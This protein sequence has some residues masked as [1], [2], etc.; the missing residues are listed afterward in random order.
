[1]PKASEPNNECPFMREM[2][3]LC[4]CKP[5]RAQETS[6]PLKRLKF[7]TSPDHRAKATVQMRFWPEW[8]QKAGRAGS[9][10][11]TSDVVPYR[12]VE[13]EG[14]GAG[15]EA[16]VC[17][18]RREESFDGQRCPLQEKTTDNG[19]RT[20]DHRP[21]TTRSRLIPTP[22][23]FKLSVIWGKQRCRAG[24][25]A[26]RFAALFSA[27]AFVGQRFRGLK[28]PLNRQA[29]KPALHSVAA[30]W[31][32]AGWLAGCFASIAAQGAPLEQSAQDQI[33]AL[34]KEK[35]SWTP[36]QVKMESALIHASKK[37]SGRTFAPGAP[38]LE[39]DL[40]KESDGRVLVDITAK[41]T[42]GLLA[43]I[44]RDGGEVV[45]S[46]PR[47]RAI[48]AK[49]QIDQLEKLASHGDVT[50]IKRAVQA[51]A[52]TGSVNSQGDATHLAGAA[53]SA[54]GVG[55]AG[56]KV[57]VLSDSV[58]YL[59]HSQSLG[60]LG[61][62]TVL[63]GQAGGGSGEGTAML[64][65]VHDLAPQAQLYFATAFNG[66][67]SFAQNI[68][69][70]R[71]NGCNIIIDDVGYFD[72]SPFQDGIIAQ[73][74][75]SVTAGGA[76][77]FSSAGN[78][79]NLTAGTSGTW[80][81]DF[82][83]GGAA[84]SAFLEP[85]RVHSFGANNY[86]VVTS[87]GFAVDLFWADPLGA[88]TNDY[89]LFLLDPSGSNVVS[90]SM[91]RQTGTQDPYEKLG[92]WETGQR[93]VIVKYSGNARFLHLDTQR[94]RLGTPTSGAT[95]G[96]AATTNAFDVAATPASNPYG[97][98]QAGPFP[99]PFGTNNQVEIFSS[100]GPRHVFFQA[101][102]TAITPG[103][104]TNSGGAVRQKPD[105]TAADGVATTLP[106]G[107]GLNPFYGTSAAAPHAGGLAALIWSYNP[108][109][110]TSQMRALLTTNAVDIGASGVDRDS[111][112][113][114]VMAYPALTNLAGRTPLAIN[115]QPVS[116]RVLPGNTASFNLS[117]FGSASISYAW[118]RDGAP[119]AGA[120]GSSYSLA[121][122]QIADSGAQFS[123]LVSNVQGTLL[124]SN[125]TLTIFSNSTC[126][127][128]TIIAGSSYSTAEST[129]DAPYN[130]PAPSCVY[131]FGKGVWFQ[132]TA[133]SNG[134]LVLDT[135]GSD[136]N[137]GLGL[138]TGGCGALNEAGCNAFAGVSDS[139]GFVF[140]RLTNSVAAGT[141]YYI[142][143]G[144]WGGSSGGYA[145]SGNLVFQLSFFPFVGPPSIVSQ[146]QDTMRTAGQKAMFSVDALG[147][148]PLHYQWQRGS[149]AIS[150]ATT[151]SYTVLSSQAAD[152]GLYN[153]VI[154]NL[155]GSVT[156]APARLIFDTVLYSFNG[157][158]GSSPLAGLIQ[159]ND[160]NFYG[161]TFSGGPAGLGTIFKMTTNGAVSTLFNFQAY[162]NGLYPM[163]NLVQASD[164]N[165]YGTTYEGG[166]NGFG[167]I[168][169]ISVNGVFSVLASLDFSTGAN[170][171]GN[172]VQGLD[173]G[174]YGEAI[175]GGASDQG[176]IFKVTTNGLLT[177]VASFHGTNGIYPRGGLVQGA[178]GS[179]Y[180]TT[181]SG[182]ANDFG[183]IFKISTNGTMTSLVSFN[184]GN[185]SRPRGLL[186]AA[187]GNFYGTTESGFT[188]ST[189]F[190]MTPGGVITSFFPFGGDD[191]FVP[192]RYLFGISPTGFWPLAGLVQG[193]DGILYGTALAGG[194]LYD[195]AIF[196]ITTNGVL[197]SR[198]SLA[199]YNGVW[200]QTA[201]TLGRDG[202]I[203]GTTP[204][205]GTD[206]NGY[207][208][209]YASG[210]G[211][212]FRLA[213]GPPSSASPPAI[214]SE[215][216]NRIAP[217]GGPANFIVRAVSSA[218]VNYT[219]MRNGVPMAGATQS[220]L[221]V[222]NIQP[223]DSGARFSCLVSNALGSLLSS[224]AILNVTASS[225]PGPFYEF[226]GMDGSWPT[227][228][229]FQASDGNFYGTTPYG[230]D[231]GHG[232]LFSL[233]TNGVRTTLFS[234]AGTNGSAPYGALTQGPD[235]ALYGTTF[236][237]GIGLYGADTASYF[238]DNMLFADT[239]VGTIFRFTTKGPAALASF[240]TLVSL[241]F[242][243]NAPYAGLTL[244]PDGN[245]YGTSVSG[246]A[247]YS[248]GSIFRMTPDG[249]LTTLASFSS[250]GSSGYSPYGGLVYGG[251]GYFYGTTY[252]GG[253][254]AYGTV[255]RISTNGVLTTLVS[256]NQS[257]GSHPYSTLA[258]GTDGNFYGTTYD[259]GSNYVGTVF[260]VT[261]GGTLTSLYSFDGVNGFYPFG[262]LA[263]G[264]DGA[265]YGT[266]YEGGAAG[267]GTVYR[268]TSSG[269][270]T[271]LFSLSGTNGDGGY[272]GLMVARD[273]NLYSTANFGGQGY[274]LYDVKVGNGT[275]VRVPLIY[276]S[277]P[278]VIVS[279]PLNQTLLAG[280]TA[281]FSISAGGS[282]PLSYFWRRNGSTISGATQSSYS[283][284][285]MQLADSG[286]QFSCLVSN[287]LG[288]LLSSNAVLTVVL[289]P[290]NTNC[291]GATLIAS[292]PYST[293]ES[294]LGAPSGNPTPSC[295]SSFGSGVWFQY[296]APVSQTISIDSAGSD[297][298]TALAVYNGTCGT[299]TELACNDDAGD[300]SLNSGVTVPVNTGTTYFI[301]AGGYN[302]QT[303]NLA[304]HV[305]FAN[306]DLCANATVITSPFFTTNE[307]TIG[308][309]SIGDPQPPCVY[310]PGKGVWFQYTP[311]LNG[312]LI[313][314]T[315]GSSF[316]TV[317][318]L[319]TGSCGA[320]SPV[321]CSGSGS[322]ISLQVT[323]GVTYSILAAG[324]N[325]E[326][327]NLVFHLN[328]YLGGP[329]VVYGPNSQ[330][331]PVGGTASFSVTAYGALPLTYQW[332]HNGTPIAGATQSFYTTNNVP[333]A[334][335]GGQFSC[336]VSNSVGP[337]LSSNAVLTVVP[338]TAPG[339]TETALA[340][341]DFTNNVFNPVGLFQASDGYLYGTADN[342]G[343]F[344]YG[345][346][347]RMTT[348]GTP[349]ILVSFDYSTNG[350]YP[351][352][353]LMQA[354]DGYLYGTTYYGGAHD[355][356][357]VFRLSTNGTLSTLFSFNYNNGAQPGAGVIQGFDGYFYGTTSYGGTNGYGTVF[358]MT[359]NGVLTTLFSFGDDAHG[360]SPNCDL[361][362]GSDGYLYG[363]TPLGGT[364]ENGTVFKISTNGALTTLALFDYD[365]GANPYAGLTKGADGDFYGMAG[366]GG[367]NGYGTV[368][369][370]T[371]H[372]KL[373]TL[374][375]FA[376]D[377]DGANPFSELIQGN[378]GNFYGTTPSG[379]RYGQ[380]VLFRIAPNGA[381][382][383]M[384]QFDGYNGSGPW[385]RL[386]QAA[387]AN[388]YGVANYGGPL[389]N[390][391]VFKVGISAPLQIISQPAN[392]TAFA[393]EDVALDVAA[394]G[395]LP[396]NFHWR[397]RGTNLVDSGNMAGAHT[398][399][400]KFT[401]VTPANAGLYQVVVSNNSMSVTSAA[402]FLQVIVSP[403]IIVTQPA[404]QSVLDGLTA[405]FLVEAEG[406]FPLYYQWLHDGTNLTD[407]A[408]I[409]GSQD[410][411]LVIAA[412]HAADGGV[413]S[414]LV[415][416]DLGDVLSD[417]AVLA[418]IPVNIA[419]TAF[420]EL[421]TFDPNTEGNFVQSP[422]V[423][424]P[425]GN[426]Y[427][428]TFYGGH[429]SGTVFRLTKAGAL[430]TMV[431]FD[432]TNGANPEAGLIVGA[433]G[434]LYGVTQSTPGGY[435][436]VFRMTANGSLATVFTF[437]SYGKGA[438]ARELMQA[439]D[440]NFYGVTYAGGANG[441]GTAFRLTPGGV[442]TTLVNFDY[443]TSGSYPQA[444]LVQGPGGI[445][446]GTT[447]EG[448]T[449]GSGAVFSLT[450][451]GL[452][453][454]RATFYGT[455]GATPVGRLLAASDGYLYGS[456]FYGGAYGYG[457]LF[458]MA[459]NGALSTLISFDSTSNGTQAGGLVQGA[460]SNF[461]GTTYS[462]GLGGGG[463]VFKLTPGGTL[464]SIVWFEGINGWGPGTRMVQASD[465][466][467]YGT[468]A[469]IGG[470]GVG[471]DTVFSLTV[472][473]FIRNPFTEAAASD[474]SAYASSLLAD[475]VA[476][477]GDTL[478]FAKVSGPAW[479]NVAGDG[480]L[481][482][483]PLTAN[484]GTNSF[485]VGLSDTNG[486]A[487]TATM[488]IVVNPSAPSIVAQPAGQT[489]SIGA[490]AT[491]SVSAAGTTP[492]VYGWRRNGAPISGT[493]NSS[494]TF[495]NAQ[496]SDSG[497]LFSCLVTNA[498]GFALSSNA[499]L[500]VTTTLAN[501]QCAGAIVIA[502]SSYAN[503]QSTTYASS[504]SDPAPS[505]VPGFGNGVWYQ[506]ATP[507]AGLLT[508]DT[509][510]SDFDTGLAIYTGACGAL[511]E[512][513][514]NDDA[515]GI[516]SQIT[517]AVSTA[518]TYRILAG[519]YAAHTGNLVFHL[520][521]AS[522]TPSFVPGSVAFR[523][524]GGFQF[525]LSGAP[526][527]HYDVL[528]STNFQTWT[529]LTS[530][531]LT[532]NTVILV[533][534]NGRVPRR[535]YRA[536]LSP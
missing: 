240:T 115:I 247:N 416:D 215:P 41:V 120:T 345:G 206:F 6:K 47:F 410:S 248:Y 48:R 190:R 464:T 455:N 96:H 216:K 217:Q 279:Q 314:D 298:D 387:D 448:G 76:L 202:N 157:G 235:G 296:T 308:A 277:G 360:T 291:A 506:F 219:W 524:N 517:L 209:G 70:L 273:G 262:G 82:V 347:F 461:Y 239:G 85:G 350:A 40:K 102:G 344:G 30:V 32:A 196:G 113:G 418:I 28:S 422:L 112:A 302:G 486:W 204:W 225:D 510:G 502:S 474:A 501:D 7:S 64:E 353:S 228:P 399:A 473:T 153:C 27:A 83:D 128:A 452:F 489:V 37:Q 68:L 414:V 250:S 36:F 371:P 19:P 20:A 50:F 144:G 167:A 337:T 165:L 284:N 194:L 335:S 407:N 150:G 23:P 389:G 116:Q 435:G 63:P 24:F 505:C 281:N 43:Q 392:I 243:N 499:I 469:G 440:G 390:G 432:F 388:L 146:P 485:T 95:V 364:N 375:S 22:L 275:I 518:T 105:I 359:T 393:G 158:D 439:P 155:S 468:T 498:Y 292:L 403:P 456:T 423:E 84:D 479:L 214:T 362:Q 354:A 199:G 419:G 81:G 207:A 130:G 493:T 183:T 512:V 536:R 303:G 198:L 467:F 171:S 307:S 320:L 168:F 185:G 97:A 426:L 125:A 481:S 310:N 355:G 411:E 34:L 15:W 484:L 428:T 381:F 103:N 242:Q 164:G 519:G 276:T 59:A 200:P 137:T 231:Y 301:R 170:P 132:W 384:V 197:T 8:S 395:T 140:S 323:N 193:T 184:G 397:T 106:S 529:T 244:G 267:Y 332:R 25:P 386:V 429:G 318:G 278:P 352:P 378:D 75:N 434:N 477:A 108:A 405:R 229:L 65:I 89:D 295:V 300:G 280:A 92:A 274:D 149:A 453:T 60:D 238:P 5:P 379:G 166:A 444:G 324:Y 159:A 35:A 254:D 44:R 51:L 124:S 487:N 39:L 412:A 391:V 66:E 117:A 266:T 261:P 460:D 12:E 160:G 110:T 433:D 123:C 3:E 286:A 285:N 336:L 45:N 268:I 182:G 340:A 349:A 343:T 259:G 445:L 451:N 316:N 213:F 67:A 531:T 263:T 4:S 174:L 100:D 404:D 509:F 299:L 361:V 383:W 224:D 126:A 465:G 180:G 437:D 385:G 413:Y 490:A 520:A 459:T 380:G 305:A 109:L 169:R 227:A 74:V 377:P 133:P 492:F 358:K 172:L 346:I 188:G 221:T 327:G 98:S 91:T 348:N 480:S 534:T 86:N 71:S 287:A 226:S 138:W 528:T 443:S 90:I 119:I 142:E 338:F 398:T 482:G 494:Y 503:Q 154:S 511:T 508:V 87:P 523:T 321:T 341:F 436:T 463:T 14:M 415:S 241:G 256:F 342:G 438:Y 72:E 186:L 258:R 57:G 521:F 33:A 10:K 472:P 382:A 104:F 26:C 134:R 272:G 283:T 402:A 38:K 417:D 408:N 533:D 175:V 161:T 29:G 319:Y 187:D 270:I 49:L 513:A 9:Q 218:P 507:S 252:S 409:S 118:R 245:F 515:G 255:Y 236:G 282:A 178:D 373:T 290:A 162:T 304:L 475:A 148:M 496:L 333:L 476:P 447:S 370:V 514:C 363:T 466:R 269:A 306:N 156:S 366:G 107:S 222:T 339:V 181:D 257:N 394:F 427:G 111:G 94:G 525:T 78:S 62:V 77:Y 462:G 46:F 357:T 129:V 99:N 42:P 500:K 191:V 478:S 237:G 488:R 93:I 421:H 208:N 114:I 442:L 260:Q 420:S 367:T 52:N 374:Y 211:L 441:Y 201:L 79:G 131:E 21:Q 80:E 147:A 135:A 400:L 315:S 532:N 136:F 223:S 18:G 454:I 334:E 69:D 179:L 458:R 424:G 289:P 141:T 297:F 139:G 425:D 121:N 143:A 516:N 249:H 401:S 203:Y 56:I 293:N 2:I 470:L 446:Y 406:D 271:S 317:L 526:G 151:S 365:N 192:P 246:G 195:G 177:L 152:V 522:S 325:G 368:F 450:T 322:A 328:A 294:T 369:K 220:S 449:S 351:S 88:S 430:T 122:A 264:P 309:T 253:A 101:D 251:D 535:F 230:G 234:F 189:V 145:S 205:G 61:P 457:T 527:S 53:R 495:N 356:G 530:L 431:S 17:G 331:I 376:G 330:T 54:F 163:G 396:M 329:T 313:L 1:M 55:G 232:T 312:Q 13:M 127:G 471:F 265:F 483:T 233:T 176:T 173:G 491:F 11:G 58:D 73:A 372:G 311:P 210:D 326:S 212:L 288:T 16:R 497:S 31:V 504:T